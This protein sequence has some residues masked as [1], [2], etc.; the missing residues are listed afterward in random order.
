MQVTIE[1]DFDGIEIAFGINAEITVSA[2]VNVSPYA[3]H[4]EVGVPA[5][6]EYNWSPMHGNE[7]R[8]D[9]IR[10]YDAENNLIS[11]SLG[12]N[13]EL[14]LAATNEAIAQFKRWFDFDDDGGNDEVNEQIE[15]EL[16]SQ[17][18]DG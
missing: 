2:D 14:E 1:R 3:A 7:P 6:W 15:S 11:H 16:I 4:D 17:A 13:P 12:M 10:L 9:D 8:I 5:G 18:Y